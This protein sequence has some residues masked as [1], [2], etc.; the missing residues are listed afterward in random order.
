MR[1]EMTPMKTAL[2][3]GI[4]IACSSAAFAQ[5][6]DPQPA[7]NAPRTITLT[8]CV[9]GG[10]NAQPITLAN[11]MVVPTAQNAATTPSP[12]PSP[13]SSGTTQ[14]AG[15]A[16]GVGTAGTAAAG[17]G[18][19]A[20]AG[21]GVG[22]PGAAG[23]SGTAGTA[24][25]AGTTGVAGAAGTPPAATPPAG[26]ASASVAGT[27]P[28]GSSGSSVSGYRL[29]GSD[30]SSW[31]GRRVQIVGSIVPAAPGAAPTAAAGGAQATFPEFRVVSVQP[32]TG[33]CP[34]K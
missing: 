20:T 14:P 31:L 6:P 8:G 17:A 2:L 27:A 32:M 13:P 11:A 23:T 26:A 10:S 24:A 1:E 18:T 33:D 9:A 15:A 5:T 19:A 7:A 4:A 3:C 16:A 22:T 30:M 28:A 25:P 12:V 34:Q 21:A 29:S